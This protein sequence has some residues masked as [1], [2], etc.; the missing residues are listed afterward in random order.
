[1]KSRDISIIVQGPT[2]EESIENRISTSKICNNIRKIFPESEIILSTYINSNINNIKVDKILLSQD[3]GAVKFEEGNDKTN[4][5][6]RMLVSSKKGIQAA[7]RKFILKIRSDMCPTSRDFIAHW[8]RLSVTP[9]AYGIF[10][11]QLLAYPIYSLQF[12]GTKHRMPKPFHVSDWAFF[13]LSEDIKFLFDIPLVDEPFFSRYFYSHNQIAFDTIPLIKWQYSPEQYLFYTAFRKKYDVNFDNK[14]DYNDFNIKISNKAVFNNFIF[15]DPD[16]WG[17]IHS[18]RFYDK[19][20]YQYDDTCYYG[21]IQFGVCIKKR[22]A[23]GLK[24]T[25]KDIFKG[26]FR[27]NYNDFFHHFLF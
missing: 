18:K 4:N 13:G 1:M 25:T 15:I 12:E 7:N 21:I 17:L 14:Q 3:P 24:V 26:I 10:K 8:K 16:M 19:P 23:L 9:Q 27:K 22:I 5:I 2:T 11:K 6:N 20:L